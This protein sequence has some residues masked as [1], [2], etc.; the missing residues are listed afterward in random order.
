MGR[1]SGSLGWRRGPPGA[2]RRS[3]PFGQII[4]QSDE[5]L[6]LRQLPW[7]HFW[8]LRA[9]RLFRAAAALSPE[10]SYAPPRRLTEGRHDGNRGQCPESVL[11]CSGEVPF[12]GGHRPYPRARLPLQGAS[13][14]L[15][16][17]SN[18]RTW[19]RSSRAYLRIALLRSDVC[20]GPVEAATPPK[21]TNRLC[22]RSDAVIA[23]ALRNP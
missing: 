18:S 19:L 23:A 6:S 14:F 20:Q 17:N 13:G 15:M 10:T 11:F 4:R 21:R 5:A 3:S 8:L 9:E 7:A 1:G 22:A 12:G 2:A 16:A